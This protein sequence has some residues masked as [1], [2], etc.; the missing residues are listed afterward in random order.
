MHLPIYIIFA[1][2]NLQETLEEGSIINGMTGIAISHPPRAKLET[3]Q[4]FSTITMQ[5]REFNIVGPIQE[6]NSHCIMYNAEIKSS[7]E[8]WEEDCFSSMQ[9]VIYN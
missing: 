7:S 5:G 4:R 9:A 1:Q 6:I 3:S 2:C 8:S